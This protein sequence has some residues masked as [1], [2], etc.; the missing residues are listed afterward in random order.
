[1]ERAL[2][3]AVVPVPLRTS[4]SSTSVRVTVHAAEMPQRTLTKSVRD[5]PSFGHMKLAEPSGAMTDIYS[6]VVSSVGEN[7]ADRMDAVIRGR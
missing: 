3:L 6:H 2:E 4:I 1:L 5:A 7:A